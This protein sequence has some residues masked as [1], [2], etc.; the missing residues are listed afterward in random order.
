MG[1]SVD[2]LHKTQGPAQN[3][4]CYLHA[5]TPTETIVRAATSQKAE[6]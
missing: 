2:R 6:R 3:G 4:E 1:N 5:Y